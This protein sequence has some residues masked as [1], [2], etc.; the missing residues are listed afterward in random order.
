MTHSNSWCVLQIGAREH[1]AIPR[2]LHRYRQLQSLLT[3]CWL[4]PSSLITRLPRTKRLSG[5]WHPELARASVLSPGYAALLRE[6]GSRL[7]PFVRHGRPTHARNSRFQAFAARTI[8]TINPVP[9]CIFS[10]SYAARQPF[11][12]AQAAGCR[13]VLGQIDCGPAE[14]RVVAVEQR[15]YPH[16]LTSWR[17]EP[18]DYWD[19]WREEL[20]L[21][22]R[23]VVNSRW[24][25]DC[26][27]REGVPDRKLSIVP[28]VYQAHAKRFEPTHPR[29]G[30]SPA[31]FRL[32]F[33]G[34]VGLRKGIARL[35]DAMRILHAEPVVLTMAGPAELDPAT[36]AGLS[37]VQWLGPLPRAAVPAAY[38][39]ADAMILPSL[40]DG[41]A[42]TQLES[43]AN[44]CPVI[45][46]RNCGDVVEHGVN[47]WLLANLEPE[48]IAATILEAMDTHRQLPRPISMPSF[49]IDDLGK[50]L[51][52]LFAVRG[53][54]SDWSTN[55]A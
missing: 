39:S 47:G 44:H 20:S 50:V 14:D 31:V 54:E 21:A 4:P 16:L 12:I 45:A 36:W 46:S 55:T 5:R 23:I 42:I 13:T 37:N 34:T 52:D 41:F 15:R 43:L 11:Q 29:P 48:T 6:V 38:A 2:A 9:H 17:A 35:L 26:M 10:Y 51:I 1:Y 32:L 28:L 19:Q 30:H 18:S 22:D 24:S 7:N 3:D 25:Y 53:E 40:S 8:A 33:L 49:G 27:I